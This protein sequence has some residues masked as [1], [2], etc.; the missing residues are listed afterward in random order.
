IWG[1]QTWARQSVRTIIARSTGLG[2]VQKMADGKPRVTAAD[3]RHVVDQIVERF[4]PA[5]IWLFGSFAYGTP[6]PDSDVDLLIAMDTS[7]RNVQQAVEIRKAVAFPFPVDLLV[8]TPQQIAERL[9]LGDVFFHEV[10]T[11]GIVLHETADAGVGVKKPRV[12]I[13]S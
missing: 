11:K 3:I 13:R 2:R 7:L 5:K 1:K 12:T 6:T 10:L 4:H 9:A 8:R